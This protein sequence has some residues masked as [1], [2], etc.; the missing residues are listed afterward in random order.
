M[1]GGRITKTLTT[2]GAAALTLLAGTYLALS[3]A[4]DT[5]PGQ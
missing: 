2:I 3:R 1:T 4:E 5:W